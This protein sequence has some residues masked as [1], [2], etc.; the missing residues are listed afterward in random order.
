M[1]YKVLSLS[2]YF[3]CKRC[4]FSSGITLRIV[5]SLRLRMKKKTGGVFPAFCHAT[6]HH[7]FITCCNVTRSGYSLMFPRKD[8]TL[9]EAGVGEKRERNINA[10]RKKINIKKN[11]QTKQQQRAKSK[12]TLS[13]YK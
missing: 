3:S 5:F 10:I 11:K 1:I 13:V 4:C 9:I 8:K 2:A 12:S 7:V 6:F